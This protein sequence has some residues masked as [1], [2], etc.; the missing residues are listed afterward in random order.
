M[1]KVTASERRRRVARGRGEVPS[2]RSARGSRPTSSHR[3]RR[4]HHPRRRH[5]LRRSRLRRFPPR[6]KPA[7]RRASS[8][9]IRA[10]TTDWPRRTPLPST[11]RPSPLATSSP[12]K[13]R[14]HLV[15]L[16]KT[17]AY[18]RYVDAQRV[19]AVALALD[20]IA[21]GDDPEDAVPLESPEIHV[22]PLGHP[23]GAVRQHLEVGVEA[24]DRPPFGTRR[25]D[26]GEHAAGCDRKD[27]ERGDEARTSI[28]PNLTVPYPCRCGAI[29]QLGE[30]LNRT[31]EVGGSNPPSSTA[32]LASPPRSTQSDRR[33][34]PSRSSCSASSA[35]VP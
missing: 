13:A 3:R 20:A 22:D 1:S 7:C 4:H 24:I 6:S 32:C 2:A 31:Q 19:H 27:A 8:R 18:G 26:R 23:Q 9:T 11:R 25:E 33:T 17:I 35:W 30:R 14:A 12:A 10:P 21:H 16:P 29:A 5:R 34:S 15:T 28:A